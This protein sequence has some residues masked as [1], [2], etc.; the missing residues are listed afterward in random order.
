MSTLQCEFD[1]DTIK[2]WIFSQDC[3][4]KNFEELVK[5]DSNRINAN[6]YRRILELTDNLI[7]IK[8]KQPLHEGFDKNCGLKGSKLS[9]G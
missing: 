7:S 6:N 1:C 9:G 3:S 5:S 4:Q 8:A 2:S